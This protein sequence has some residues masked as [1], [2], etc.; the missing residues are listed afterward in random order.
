MDII[1]IRNTIGITVFT[2]EMLN[3]L[4]APNTVNINEKIS[5]MAK[6]QKIIRLKRGVYVFGEKY[7][8]SAVD[9]IAAANMLY[10]PSY[11]SFEYAL[12]YYGLIPE[13]VYEVTSASL[14]AKKSFET[15]V[16]R[17]GYRKIPLSAFSIG[18]DWLFDTQS[19]GRL[20]ATPEKAL[21]DKV[22]VDRGVSSMSQRQLGDYLE[23]DLRIEWH[24][25]LTLDTELIRK[26]AIAY[27]SKQLREL[28]AMIAKRKKNG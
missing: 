6:N 24:D 11:V 26:I 21:C 4:L 2:H 13:R 25:L 3:A 14:R 19:G 12:S 16:G 8:N 7:R 17:F 22:R 27:R 9:M 10:A 5:R 18:V 23:Y 1:D 15:P 20:I 28:G